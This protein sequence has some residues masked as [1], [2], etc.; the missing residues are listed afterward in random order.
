MVKR[1]IDIDK[2][3]S[4]HM[5]ETNDWRYL[6]CGKQGTAE[7]RAGH[8]LD[9]PYAVYPTWGYGESSELLEEIISLPVGEDVKICSDMKVPGDERP[10]LGQEHRVIITDL[11]DPRTAPG[12]QFYAYLRDMQEENPN[13][14]IHIHGTYSSR[15]AWGMNWGAA[16][17]EPRTVA[18]K[19]RI[20]LPSGKDIEQERAPGHAQWITLM[21]FKP[22]EL[23]VP[24]NR[25]MYNIK[26]AVWAAENFTLLNNFKVKSDNEP[27]DIESSN[28]D[29]V[30]PTTKS[31]MSTIV[32]PK[33][34][35]RFECNSCSLSATCKYY[36]EGAV[37]S[38]PGAE[39][40]DLALMFKSRDTETIL[41]GLG[42]LVARN[43]RRAERGM[44]DEDTFDE[45][46]PET[47]KIVNAVFEQAVKLAKL[48]DPSLR[49]AGTAVQVNVAGGATAAIEAGNPRKLV[50][51]AFRELEQRGYTRDQ[52]TPE[53]ISQL[54][55]P[56]E[57][58]AIEGTVISHGS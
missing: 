32:K 58:Q 37:C 20:T 4:L 55:R 35:D 13:C 24:R 40:K 18:A 9:K 38:V 30:A 19:G 51:E 45:V 52:I 3:S 14:I 15:L 12:R 7:I 17:F 8:T 42:E 25:C 29:Y 21:G 27:V 48:R 36:R 57:T 2:Y 41:D 16:D 49:S 1:K 33:P 39:T 46:N 23:A 5:G 31:H 34:G 26:S 44:R 6:I 10:V 50:T 22:S 56:A 28:K 43:A 53:L 47:T 54:I 11:P